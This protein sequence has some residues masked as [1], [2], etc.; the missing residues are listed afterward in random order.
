MYLWT[1]IKGYGK[2]GSVAPQVFHDLQ[3][4]FDRYLKMLGPHDLLGM[5]YI[6]GADPCLE[7]ALIEE[8]YYVFVIVDA[9]EEDHLIAHGYAG[10]N[11]PS[12]GLYG[13]F[14]QLSRMIELYVHEEGMIF[15]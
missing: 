15:F 13:I 14:R 12:A 1:N 9:F 11:D 3:T 7:K 4:L 5:E 10:V 8:L 2:A 6:I